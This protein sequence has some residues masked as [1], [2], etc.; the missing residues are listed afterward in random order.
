MKHA[1]R[2]AIAQLKRYTMTAFHRSGRRHL[3]LTGS[4]GR[5]KTTLLEAMLQSRNIPGVRSF[6]VRKDRLTPPEKIVLEDRLTGEQA[7]IGRFED[8]KMVPQTDALE[9]LGVQMLRRAASS[10]SDWVVV[11]EI[12][13]LENSSPAYR[14]A[15]RELFVQKRVLAVL[16]KAETPFLNEIRANRNSFLFDLD[17]VRSIIIFQKKMSK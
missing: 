15:L 13:F 4:R 2:P 3:L 11:D 1:K 10:R 7:V 6:A 16:R 12:G 5:G 17:D 9:S 8:G 14:E